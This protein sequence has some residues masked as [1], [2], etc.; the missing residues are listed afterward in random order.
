MHRLTQGKLNAGYLVSL[1]KPKQCNRHSFEISIEE[2][3]DFET[4]IKF[5]YGIS[6]VK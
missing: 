3:V 1:I 5:Y 4:I 2:R 6:E